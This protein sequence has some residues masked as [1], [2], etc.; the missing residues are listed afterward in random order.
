M[1]EITIIATVHR[2][3]GI[4]NSNELYKIIERIA[5]QII[6][7]EIS[8]N[9]F[10]AIYEGSL[11]GTLETN[12]IKRYLQ[13]HPIAHVPVDLDIKELIDIG[14]KNDIDELFDIFDHNHEYKDLSIQHEILSQRLG[15]QYLNSD[16]CRE[17]LEHIHFLEEAILRNMNQE[18]LSKT[19]KSWL[20]I[21]DKRENE[22]IKNIYRHSDLNKYN[23][24][25]FLVGTEHRISIINKISII[26]KN[27]KLGLNWIS[28]Y[29][30]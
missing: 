21:H 17:L 6:F 30:N 23:K 29:F 24:A 15:F 11:Y 18:K 28:N 1:Y 3:R 19:Y 12:T 2:E 9:G 27:N 8:P 14:F 20:N 5:P 10:L 16:Q 4:C 26:E 25:L 22:M 13:K 7:E